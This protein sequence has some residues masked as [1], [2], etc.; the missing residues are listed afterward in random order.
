MKTPTPINSMQDAPPRKNIAVIGSGISGLSCA[1]LLSK[2]QNVTLFEKDDRLGGH[3]NT[4]TFDLDKRPISVDTGFIVYNPVNYPNLVKFFEQ[5]G[6]K[7]CDTD[8][9]F[10]VSVNGGELEYSGS[11]LSG[12]LAQK[13]NLLRPAFWG[14]VA[15]LLRFYRQSPKLLQAAELEHLSL[16]ELLEKHRYGKSF[17]YNHLL[18][19]GA[20]IWSV[21][22][23]KMLNYPALSFM[24]FCSNHG[25]TQ[26]N[27][28]PQWRT[29]VGGSRQYV[30]KIAAALQ[31][32][33]RL[34][35]RIQSVTRLGD[36]VALDDIHGNREIFD[37]V[38][39]ACHSDQALALLADPTSEEQSLLSCFPY[40]RNRAFL[41]LDTDLMPKRQQVWSSWNYLASNKPVAKN[42]QLVSDQKRKVSVSYW[43]N[44]LQP[45][46]T[47]QPV[48]VSLNPLKMPR[49]G[50]I[51]RSFFYDHPAF[52][53]SSLA[54]QK[55]LWSLQ[56]KQHTWFCGAYF[57]YGFHE[58]G[59]QSGLAVAEALG[60][61]VRPWQLE[62]PNS[63]IEIHTGSLPNT[64]VELY[65]V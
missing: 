24:R 61:V 11:G 5:L 34:N 17:I 35:T 42:G 18:P 37:D 56:G 59:L 23:D 63:R 51:I 9:S 25:L 64:A 15:D 27:N 47:E 1:W 44:Q 48:M 30:D 33:I 7:T 22:V 32:S 21:P 55:Q 45:L 3:S 12:L 52:D 57:G 36:H 53:Q 31:G 14:M 13:R 10:S 28:R 62:E 49:S 40:Q 26:V 29:V 54:A 8:M 38:V 19:M 58:D 50:T 46:A 16:G 4:V 20:A 65:C 6:V 60:S 41:H 2:S 39:F 43:M